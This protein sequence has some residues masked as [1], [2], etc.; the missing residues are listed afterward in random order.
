MSK[1]D[2]KNETQERD[3]INPKEKAMNLAPLLSVSSV[4]QLP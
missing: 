1:H 2:P 4:I 3:L